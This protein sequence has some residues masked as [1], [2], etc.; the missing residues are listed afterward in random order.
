MRMIR[1]SPPELARAFPGPNASRRVTSQP[2]CT[3]RYAV[4]APKQPAPTTATEGISG[5]SR[6]RAL[7]SV[8]LLVQGERGV[9]VERPR[10]ERAGRLRRG[11]RGKSGEVFAA[12]AEI[13]Q[14]PRQLTGTRERLEPF[15]KARTGIRSAVAACRAQQVG[16]LVGDEASVPSHDVRQHHRNRDRGR[17]P[18]AGSQWLRTRMGGAKHRVLDRYAGL[19]RPPEHRAAGFDVVRNGEN[20]FVAAVHA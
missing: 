15:G 11:V 18:V 1:V 10:I 6:S 13:A 9:S 7:V 8:R 2:A 4:H 3:R 5:N 16:I 12:G 19:M 14:R 17:G 20:A